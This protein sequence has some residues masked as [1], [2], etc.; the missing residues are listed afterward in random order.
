MAK[1]VLILR[2]MGLDKATL[3]QELENRKIQLC[4]ATTIPDI[5]ELV[6]EMEALEFLLQDT[7]LDG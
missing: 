5:E 6:E 4:N 1:Q 3:E 2:F 7:E